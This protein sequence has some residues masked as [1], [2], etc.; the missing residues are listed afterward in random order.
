MAGC[1][2]VQSAKRA[3]VRVLVYLAGLQAKAAQKC[4]ANCSKSLVKVCKEVV[5]KKGAA[6]S[7]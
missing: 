5:L 6:S 3:L 7:G 4:A 2:V 1:S